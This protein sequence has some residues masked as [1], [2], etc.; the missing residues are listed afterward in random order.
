LTSQKVNIHV[1]RVFFNTSLSIAGQM[2]KPALCRNKSS[3][4][5]TSLVINST[6][7]LWTKGL[8]LHPNYVQW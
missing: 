4:Y 2:A 8:S 5:I 7:I 3:C 6:P 1:H